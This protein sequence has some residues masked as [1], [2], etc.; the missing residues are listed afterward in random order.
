MTGAERALGVSDRA[1]AIRKAAEEGLL[2]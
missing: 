1:H 2:D